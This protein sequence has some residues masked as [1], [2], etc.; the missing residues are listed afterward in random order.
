MVEAG[1]GPARQSIKYS[2]LYIFFQTPS[3]DLGAVL[4]DTRRSLLRFTI[5]SA[6]ITDGM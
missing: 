2:T 1:G 5:F 6:W 3:L 4:V